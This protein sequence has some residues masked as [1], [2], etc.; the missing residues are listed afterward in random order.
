MAGRIGF[1][2]S[3]ACASITRVD[4]LPKAP[5]GVPDRP[6]PHMNVN[7]NNPPGIEFPLPNKRA[8]ITCR[9]PVGVVIQQTRIG[10]YTFKGVIS[11]DQSRTTGIK[12][13]DCYKV[14]EQKPAR[15]IWGV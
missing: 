1:E 14:K 15:R 5:G 12:H 11:H 2:S 4:D 7:N 8:S 13:N 10:Y 3:C 9:C 6:L